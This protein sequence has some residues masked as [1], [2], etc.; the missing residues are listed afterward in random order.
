MNI[1]FEDVSLIKNYRLINEE[2]YFIKLNLKFT[3]GN[4]YLIK[5]DNSKYLL[6]KLIMNFIEPTF[7]NIKVGKFSLRRNKYI[8]NINDLRKHI[9]YLPYDYDEK[10]NYQTVNNI[11]KESLYNYGYKTEE[12]DALVEDIIEKTGCYL[13]YKQEKLSNL[14]SITRYKLYLASLLI[15]NP[16]IIIVEKVINNDKLNEYFAK[17]AHEENKIVIFIGNY[18]MPVDKTY[19]INNGIVNEVEQ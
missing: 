3:P 8:S 6:G 10:F 1:E 4:M 12:D 14:D 2:K 9:A 19:V 13:D 7:G 15:I 18:K 5:G 16:D 17:L 11:F